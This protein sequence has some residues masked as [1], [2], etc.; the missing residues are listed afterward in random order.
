MKK[1]F[2][3]LLMMPAPVLASSLGIE[4]DGWQNGKFYTEVSITAKWDIKRLTCRLYDT[5]G[6]VI[7]TDYEYNLKAG[8]WETL[9]FYTYQKGKPDKIGCR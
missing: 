4:L 2:F 9:L 3:A 6:N 7:A 5:Q 1:I 8:E